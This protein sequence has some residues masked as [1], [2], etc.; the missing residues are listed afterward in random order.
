M[1]K[2]SS[3]T[4]RIPG[5]FVADW[6][7]L[8]L[9]QFLPLSCVHSMRCAAVP[10]LWLWRFPILLLCVGK[11][12][13]WWSCAVRMGTAGRSISVNTLRMN[14]MK[15]WMGWMK[16]SIVT[17]FFFCSC[18]TSVTG[19]NS[20]YPLFNTLCLVCPETFWHYILQ[21]LHFSRT[22]KFYHHKVENRC[23]LGFLL[24]LFIMLNEKLP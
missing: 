1:P 17:L 14:W 8:L 6:I 22:N 19:G 13:S 3:K 11:R 5:H 16:V 24:L 10:G 15:S 7:E 4:G 12:G 20:I 2:Y 21:V 18:I 23:C 9:I